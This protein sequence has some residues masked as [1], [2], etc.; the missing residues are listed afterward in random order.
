[1]QGE[2]RPFDQWYKIDPA[3]GCWNWLGRPGDCG[4]GSFT[5]HKHHR[6]AHVWAWVFANGEPPAGLVVDHRCNNRLCVNPGHLQV[7]TQAENARRGRNA[8]ITHEIADS[9]RSRAASGET[10]TA[11]AASIG[12][13]ITAIGLIVRGKRWNAVAKPHH[14]LK[15]R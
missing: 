10:H 7:I 9:I 3:T 6:P 14:S 11:I 15:V 2:K 4:Y 12:L 13:S 5:F 8:K 1:M